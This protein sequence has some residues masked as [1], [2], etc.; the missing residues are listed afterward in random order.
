MYLTFVK[1]VII[2]LKHATFL[3][4]SNLSPKSALTIAEKDYQEMNVDLT[5][6]QHLMA[7]YQENAVE[8][9]A[10][11]VMATD[12]GSSLPSVHLVSH[13]TL[14]PVPRPVHTKKG[15]WFKQLFL[16]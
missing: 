10:A 8:R 3:R 2:I 9:F 7:S 12:I 15:H 13:H 14:V 16:N 11:F 1:A 5:I 6:Q 4:L